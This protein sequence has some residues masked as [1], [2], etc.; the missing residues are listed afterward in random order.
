MN[1]KL[2]KE[3]EKG[4]TFQTDDFKI[5]YRKKDSISGDNSENLKETIYLIQGKAEVT[6]KDSTE[7]MTAPSKTI[8]PAKTHHKIKA[9]TD[10]ILIIFEK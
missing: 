1:I 2:I 6:L 9:I 3:N 8:F 5:L 7:T 10:I 4:K